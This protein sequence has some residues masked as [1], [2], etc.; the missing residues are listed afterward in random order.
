M[1]IALE[2]NKAKI[3]RRVIEVF[4]FFDEHRQTATVMDIVRRYDRPQSS[5]S[6]LLTSLAE[7]GLLYKD[8]QSRTYSPTPRLAA[9][10]LAAQPPIIRNGHLLTFMGR[11]AHF[12]RCGVALFGMVSTYTQ[13]FGWVAGAAPATRELGRGVSIQLSN[14]TVGLLLLS[15]VDTE[16]V[17]R[18][19]RRLNAEL[20]ADAQFDPIELGE[21]IRVFG[22]QGYATGPAGF[23]PDTSVTAMLL[24]RGE[25]ERPLALGMI[26]PTDAAFDAEA[27]VRTLERGIADCLSPVDDDF[28]AMP[29]ASVR[30]AT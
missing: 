5:T 16:Q 1:P 25:G 18:I 11:L 7:M 20:T 13:I 10:G 6:E 30:A 14:T 4:E 9:F 23:L 12:T 3:A 24:P 27:L 17:G 22:Q 2:A 28:P 29:F 21:K 8:A 19:L 26:Y 15:T